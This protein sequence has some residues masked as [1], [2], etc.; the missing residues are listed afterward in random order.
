[1]KRQNIQYHYNNFL[2]RNANPD[3]NSIDMFIF[4]SIYS[5]K[6]N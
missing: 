1:M 3:A 5:Y 4:I 6:Y 2:E